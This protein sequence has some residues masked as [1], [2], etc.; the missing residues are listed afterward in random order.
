MS[1]CPL[2]RRGVIIG[3]K[4]RHPRAGTHR[5]TADATDCAGDFFA[6]LFDFGVVGDMFVLQQKVAQLVERRAWAAK[7]ARSIRA[8]LIFLVAQW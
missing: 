3:Q 4:D 2:R 5:G 6:N 7:V 1:Y 8:F